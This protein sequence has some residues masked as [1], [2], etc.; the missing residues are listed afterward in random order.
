MPFPLAE[1]IAGDATSAA[2][3]L[4]ARGAQ[5]RAAGGLNWAE[6]QANVLSDVLSGLGTSVS[7]NPVLGH[8]L[9]GG[10]LGALAGAG[11]HYLGGDETDPNARRRGVLSSALTGGLAGAALGGGLGM[12]RRHFPGG[13]GHAPASVPDG[14]TPGVGEFTHG[15]QRYRIDPQAL[16]NDPELLQRTLG[17]SAGPGPIENLPGAAVN[18]LWNNPVAPWSGRVLPAFGAVDATWSAQR[19]RVTD[20]Q[21]GLRKMLASKDSHA[22]VVAPNR[23][24]FNQLA[25]S[26]AAM[27]DLLHGPH[28]DAGPVRNT[29]RRLFGG[30]VRGD[31]QSGLGRMRDAPAL[32]TPIGVHGTVVPQGEMA[33]TTTR[34]HEV[35]HVEQVIPRDTLREARHLGRTERLGTKLN[36]PRLSGRLALYGGIPAAEWMLNSYLSEHGK[37]QDLRELM[38]QH[39]RPIGPA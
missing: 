10:G 25:G 35:P 22:G 37:A 6:K 7:S 34:V 30:D 28:P 26:D 27:H 12:V 1:L 11:S 3:Y 4:A 39:A 8:A 38:R 2:A 5:V 16:R 33:K 29:W 24:A 32:E 15:G 9:V 23:E 14:G 17:A 21:A 31:Y 19:R 36:L 18:F 20:L 13:A